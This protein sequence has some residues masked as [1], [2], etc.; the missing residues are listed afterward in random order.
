MKSI[1]AKVA[2]LGE[3]KSK[4]LSARQ[5]LAYAAPAIGIVYM[6]ISLS[7]V[8][9]IYVKY[10]GV[11]LTT[12]ATVLLLSRVFDAITD[13]LVGYLS[14]R[15][16]ARTGSRKG[17]MVVGGLGMVVASYFLMVP[18]DPDVVTATTQVSGLYFLLSLLAFYLCFTFFQIPHLSWGS[19]IARTANE[20]SSLFTLRAIAEYIGMFLFFSVPLLPWLETSEITPQSLQWT[21]LGSAI[22]ILPTLFFSMRVVPNSVAA[23][24][25][26]TAIL[27][28]SVSSRRVSKPYRLSIAALVKNKPLKLFLFVFFLIGLSMGLYSSM[29]FIF[30]DSYLK[31]GDSYIYIALITLAIG[32]GSLKLWH[33]LATLWGKKLSLGVAMAVVACGML[34]NL[35]LQSG[36]ATFMHLLVVAAIYAVGMGAANMIPYAMM[37]EIV[38]YSSW[39]CGENCGGSLFS[40]F[41]FLQ[42]TSAALGGSIGFF[43]VGWYGFEANA[44]VHTPE[45]TVG[46]YWVVSW[47]P[48]LLSLLAILFIMKMPITAKRHGIIRRRLDSLEL[49]ASKIHSTQKC[50]SHLQPLLEA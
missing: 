16:C 11:P 20:K 18:V 12:I 8:Q 33:G 44:L 36:E 39:K 32:A 25:G 17:F 14:D 24:N 49:R 43:I 26:F 28:P 22:L 40:I 23:V 41:I 29:A 47:L 19:D 21:M 3:H 46:M 30:I 48:A 38:D 37:S 34:G 15:Y 42:K 35:T 6:G 31:M 4:G 13:P 5:N 45:S 2:V 10:F 9:G 1:S 7:V 50:S 27:V